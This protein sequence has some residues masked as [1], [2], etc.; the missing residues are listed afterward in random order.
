MAQ[1]GAGSGGTRAP[2]WTN[3]PGLGQTAV[4]LLVFLLLPIAA[5]LGEEIGW[6]GVALPHLLTRRSPLTA[7]LI[8][9]V[10]WSVWHLP[11]VLANPAL[12]VPAPFLLSVVPLA[13]LF[14]WQFLKSGG[15]LFIAVLFH[16]WYDLAFV[17]AAAI[18]APATSH[19]CGGSF[20]SARAWRPSLSSWRTEGDSSSAHGPL[21][22]GPHLESPPAS[23]LGATR[24]RAE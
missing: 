9:G 23:A 6:R 20:L 11:G 17:F 5:P 12:R 15:S 18:V 21:L 10:I 16:A 7:S 14:T 3:Q 22:L 13:V 2:I 24:D 8:L 4:L 19:G 1:D